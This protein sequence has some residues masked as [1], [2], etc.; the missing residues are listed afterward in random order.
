MTLFRKQ[1]SGEHV[2]G[3]EFLGE[4]L[5]ED[6]AFRHEHVF[7]DEDEVRHDHGA[8]AEECLQV[9]GKLS[10]TSVTRVHC[11][12]ETSGVLETDLALLHEDELLLLFLLGIQAGLDLGRN[13]RQHLHGDTVELVETSPGA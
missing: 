8:G 13:D 1:L 2:E 3:H 7:A 5:G 6:E 11:D 4:V 9:V 10:S 12:E